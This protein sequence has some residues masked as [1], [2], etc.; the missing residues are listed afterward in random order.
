[1]QQFEVVNSKLQAGRGKEFSADYL[2][3]CWE[4]SANTWPM[5]ELDAELYMALRHCTVCSSPLRPAAAKCIS[6]SCTSALQREQRLKVAAD[7]ESWHLPIGHRA[8][9]SLEMEGLEMASA[10]LPI[11]DHNKG[12]QMLQR[13][14]WKGAGLGREEHGGSFCDT[15]YNTC[16]WGGVNAV[17]GCFLYKTMWCG[18]LVSTSCFVSRTT[19]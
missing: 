19:A 11:P 2:V 18:P 14:G 9:D 17:S 13:M 6:K 12:F 3:S 16:G 15:G 10:S 7:D 5:P 1:M 4:Q 8:E